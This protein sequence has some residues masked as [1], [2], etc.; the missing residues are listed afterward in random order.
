MGEPTYEYIDKDTYNLSYSNDIVVKNKNVHS[1]I[2]LLIILM[3]IILT[4]KF[5]KMYSNSE[6][7]IKPPKLLVIIYIIF[8]FLLYHLYKI[9]LILFSN[10]VS[11]HLYPII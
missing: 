8:S 10:F 7:D 5:I 1:V 11:D 3:Y 4:Y 6:N 2:K 9:Y